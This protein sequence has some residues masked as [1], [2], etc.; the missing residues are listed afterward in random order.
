[1]VFVSVLDRHLYFKILAFGQKVLT[2]VV[3]GYL[4]WGFC[5]FDTATLVRTWRE[6]THGAENPVQQQLNTSQILLHNISFFSDLPLGHE[7]IHVA[8]RLN[9]GSDAHSTFPTTPGP[10]HIGFSSHC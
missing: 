10:V 1:M 4:S 8:S 2:C 6:R 3:L 9:G 7:K 5:R